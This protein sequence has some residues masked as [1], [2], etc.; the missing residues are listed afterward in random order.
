MNEFS[1][2]Y[3]ILFI[4]LDVLI[5]IINYHL[6]KSAPGSNSGLTYVY[7][8]S[9]RLLFVLELTSFSSYE[10]NLIWDDLVTKILLF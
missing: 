3:S 7:V 4:S 1:N 9:V 8:L 2:K 6:N 10:P 5:A